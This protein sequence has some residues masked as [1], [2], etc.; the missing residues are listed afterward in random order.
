[1]TDTEPKP[2]SIEEIADRVVPTDP[3]ISPNGR[4]IAFTASTLGRKEKRFDRAIWL[5]TDG[6]PARRFTG[7]TGNNQ[8]PCWSPD[9]TR[10]FFLAQREEGDDHRPYLIPLD[11]GEAQQLGELKGTLSAPKWS[12][13]GSRIAVLRTDPDDEAEKKRKEEKDD[14][15]IYE[16]EDKVDRLWVIDV[17]SGRARCL[18]HGK[19]HVRDYSWS[20]DG[21]HFVLI[22]S[23]G[24]QPNEIFRASSLR[25]IPASGGVSRHLADF[26]NLPADPVVRTIDEERIIAFI[27]NDHRADPSFA[28]WTI[29]FNGGTKRKLIENERAATA[30]LVADPA[31]DDGLIVSQAEGARVRQY[32]LSCGNG[33]LTPIPMDG[34]D[35]VG[36]VT[37]APTAAGETSASAVVW[38]TVDVPEEVYRVSGPGEVTR[39]SSFGTQFDGRL[40]RGELVTWESNDG[41]DI[42]GVLVYPLGY[43]EGTR[44]PLLVEVHGGP[45]W[46]W[47]DRINMSWHDWAQMMAARG[48]AVLLPNPRGSIGYGSPFEQL[49]QDDVGGGEAQ[50]LISGALA[51]VDRGLADRDR[52][53]IGGWSWGGYL[54]AWTIT[55]TDIF[56]AAV[57]GAGVANNISDHGAGDIA[58]YNTLLYPDHPYL[59]E[60]WDYYANIS[61]VRFAGNVKT[62]TLIVHGEGD[63]RVHISQ[64]QEY[65]RALKVCGV[66]VQFV[67]YPREGHGF[68]EYKHQIDLMQRVEKWLTEHTNA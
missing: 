6:Q 5:S 64:G 1:M 22:T 3:Q 47:Q 50:D 48:F 20:P 59:P 19:R 28:V 14:A 32:R 12:P 10:L 26:R 4:H 30:H 53:A 11:G 35:D 68:Q 18:T 52:L 62:P 38:T 63:V 36:S 21:E 34:L 49:L 29:P 65:Y 66:K 54:T 39:V 58:E 7:G 41:V 24:P 27:G 44:H 60:A 42:E 37:S 8:S 25:V 51:M 33:K 17:E 9:S 15:L 61:P 2:I 57:M 40:A 31:S 45:A 16:E 56:A 67:R 46:H 55:Q 23:D 13:D 43:K